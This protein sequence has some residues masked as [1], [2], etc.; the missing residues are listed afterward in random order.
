MDSTGL[1]S[2]M[3][4]IY[5]GKP[6]DFSNRTPGDINLSCQPALSLF[7]APSALVRGLAKQETSG[8]A[9]IDGGPY[10]M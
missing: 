1:I 9:Q 7:E 8:T 4:Y 6:I 2:F 3:S 5:Q 10:P